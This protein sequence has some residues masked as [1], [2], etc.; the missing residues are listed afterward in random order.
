MCILDGIIIFDEKLGGGILKTDTDGPLA[1]K[2]VKQAAEAAGV[3]VPTF[4]AWLNQPG[5]P[6][7]RAGTRWIIPVASLRRWLEAQA[8][9]DGRS[10]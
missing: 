4:R 8:V 7:F 1:Y 10:L 2:S 6:A 3:S 9:N 5:F